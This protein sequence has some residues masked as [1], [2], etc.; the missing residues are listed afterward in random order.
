MINKIVL[1]GTPFFEDELRSSLKKYDNIELLGS[2]SISYSDKTLYLFFGQSENDK[3]ISCYSNLDFSELVA[4]Q[5]IVPIL[6]SS[7]NFR[8]FIPQELNPVNAI[9]IDSTLAIGK[10]KCFILEYFGLLESN[11]K[12]FISYKRSDSLKFVHQLHDA[13]IAAHYK[14]FL[15]SYSITYGVDF[16]EYLKHELSDSSVFIFVN[17]PNYE[18]SKFTM[19]ELN[20]CNKLQMGVIEVFAPNS[21]VFKEAEFAK[22]YILPSEIDANKL[23]ES[24]VLR[25]IISVLE[26]NRLEIQ[27]FR[28]KALADQLK[29][30]VPD[31]QLNS[32]RRCYVSQN[33]DKEFYPL[34][35]IPVSFDIQKISEVSDKA[36][37]AFGFYNG[38]YCRSDVRNHINW[39]N[40]ILPV[41]VLDVSK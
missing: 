1:L 26:N 16:Q 29:A 40:G 31:V 17:T 25:D 27:S 7:T 4:N 39:L 38:L 23:F 28:E 32:D 8:D 9:E 5:Q 24:F 20:A 12:V 19:E 30:M 21:K 15:D 14:P 37:Q 41:Q 6:Q 13:L 35:H 11:R 36:K 10:L 18:L 33:K 22:R 3:D 34:Y 2:D